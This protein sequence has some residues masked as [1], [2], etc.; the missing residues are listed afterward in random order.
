ME[1]I[2]QKKFFFEEKIE[3]NVENFIK[4]NQNS[5]AGIHLD[6]MVDRR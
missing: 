4:K 6:F 3:P 1:E 5:A 2:W